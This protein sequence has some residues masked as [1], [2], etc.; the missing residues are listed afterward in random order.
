[1]NLNS[2]LKS[3]ILEKKDKRKAQTESICIDYKMQSFIIIVVQRIW[4][5]SVDLLLFLFSL[6]L[7]CEKQR[8]KSGYQAI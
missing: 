1:M 5:P 8:L 3:E 6:N 4:S 7:T 2:I